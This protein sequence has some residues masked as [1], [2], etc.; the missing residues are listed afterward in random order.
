MVG[1]TS[2]SATCLRA[3]TPR[4]AS[5]GES[6]CAGRR[7]SP[8]ASWRRGRTA[9]TSARRSASRSSI[10]PPAPRGVAGLP[11]PPVRVLVRGPRAPTR[12]AA[13]RGHVTV[14]RRDLGVR[15][16]RRPEPDHGPAGELCRL[17]AQRIS[18]DEACGLVAEGEA[19]SRPSRWRGR[20]CSRGPLR[21]RRRGAAVDDEHVAR[22]PRRR[23]GCEEQRGAG[24]IVGYPEPLHREPGGRPLLVVLEQGARNASSPARRRARSPA[25]RERARPPAGGSCER[26]PPS[27]CC[28]C[29]SRATAGSRPAT[30][31]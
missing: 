25:R 12:R 28:T 21:A 9:W 4:C 13:G 29:R 23:A 26:G 20:S 22:H 11:R 5:R 1:D 8:R 14:G 30:R 24:E 10:R 3:S 7:S 19:R 2:A 18:R 6:A 31:R 15:T 27:T 16:G 17:F